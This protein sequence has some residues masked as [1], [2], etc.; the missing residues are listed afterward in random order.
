MRWRIRAGSVCWASRRTLAQ[1]G[2][3]PSTS[4]VSR[5]A[6]DAAAQ[7]RTLLHFSAQ[8]EHFLRDRALFRGCS[9]GVYEVVRG[10]RGC[11]WCVLCHKRLRH[12]SV[13]RKRFLWDR[14]LFRGCSGGV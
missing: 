10:I 2:A 3:R 12:V 8:L 7:G 5:A 11:L 6:A 14:G 4:Q 9:G 1:S 13:Q